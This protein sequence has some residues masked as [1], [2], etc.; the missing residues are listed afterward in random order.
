MSPYTVTKTTSWFER[1][2]KSFGGIIVGLILF[3]AATILLWWNEGNFVKTQVA[4]KEAQGVTQELPDISK[5]DTSLNGQL[6]HAVGPAETKDILEDPV[7]GISINA[8][9]LERS[10]EFYQ[11]VEHTKTDRREKLG[12]GEE[13]ITTY[14]HLPDWVSKP[15]NSDSFADPSARIE[16]KNTVIYP[17]EN[18][19]VQAQNVTFGAYGLPKFLIDKISNSESF[20]PKLSDATIAELNNKMGVPASP[21][22]TAPPS[23]TP[24]QVSPPLLQA[25]TVDV[26]EPANESPTTNDNPTPLLLPAPSSWV[27]VSG[28]TV[29]LGRDPSSPT[30]GD[31]RITFKQ[32]LPGTVSLIAKLNGNTFENFVAKNGREVGLLSVGT[33]SAENMYESAHTANTVFTWILRIVGIVLVCLSLGLITAPLSVLASVVPFLGR[34][35]G[36]GTGIVC[37]LLG[38]AWSLLIIALAWLFYRPLFGILLLVVVVALVALL[39]RRGQAAGQQ[40]KQQMKMT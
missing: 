27:H 10:V 38:L 30:V 13:T 40:D 6:V 26:A 12:G 4:L 8:I 7:F 37:V 19:I 33:H 16:K 15:E 34:L 28:N 32:T 36:A 3:V 25:F 14:S 35:V 17:L 31:V 21:P 2:G 39:Y 5:V 23:N 20:S 11:W 22:V 18:L 29:Y 9:R 24:A 1:L